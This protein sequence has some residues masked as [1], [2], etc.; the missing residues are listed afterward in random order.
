MENKD[1]RIFEEL[2]AGAAKCLK[3]R[4][5]RAP[6]TLHHYHV[7]WNRIRKYMNSREIKIFDSTI[8]N[9]FLEHTY[10]DQD[11]GDLTKRD[12]DMIR[13]VEVLREYIDTG[14]IVPKKEVAVFEGSIG[15][16]MIQ[17]LAYKSSLKLAKHTLEEYE[18]QLSRFLAF[19]SDKE[20]TE[21]KAVNQLHF[22]LYLKGL[23][24]RY[25]SLPHI[26]IRVLRDF[27]RYLYNQE[28]LDTDISNLIP[29]DNFRKQPKLPSTY[30]KR[31]V[32][33]LINSIDRASKAGKRN[34]T[35]ILL[36]ARLGL[37][38]SDITNLKFRDIQWERNNIR[39]RQYK[40]DNTL[41]LPLLPEVGNAMIDYLKY[42]RPVSDD[43]HVFLVARSPYNPMSGS[44]VGTIVQNA[45]AAAE[46]DTG[47]R[48]HGPHALRHSLAGFLLENRVT[49]P[50]ISEV[51]GHEKS[52]S[53]KYYLRVDLN[54][55][56]KCMLD[57]P[58]ID[59]LFYS[60]KGGFFYE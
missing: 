57:I 55:L 52:E 10:G 15:K 3:E 9:A 39:I 16:L 38:A 19:L 33:I 53:T 5:R 4:L 30:K 54:S 20:I 17:Y 45:F 32:E 1:Q 41:E 14:T 31:E 13:A 58:A 24:P 42:G 21:I 2:A 25:S 28:I 51:L 27:F 40:T 29:K 49:L 37:R 7:L 44:G 12:R 50:V 46:I 60:Q 35:I 8:C 6:G 11:F 47:N 18:Q 36:A 22:L 59:P 26:A 56:K 43:P 34:Y 48:K 23:D